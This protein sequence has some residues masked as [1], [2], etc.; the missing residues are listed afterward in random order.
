MLRELKIAINQSKRRILSKNKAA[1]LI[2]LG[3][4]ELKYP[5]LLQTVSR[6]RKS[7]VLEIFGSGWSLSSTAEMVEPD[8]YKV[9]FNFSGYSQFDFDLYFF[10]M[11]ADNYIGETQRELLNALKI[12]HLVLKNLWSPNIDVRQIELKKYPDF[13]FI[14]DVWIPQ[15]KNRSFSQVKLIIEDRQN[16]SQI[17]ATFTSMIAMGIQSEFKTIILHGIDFMGEHFFHS[18]NTKYNASF[19]YGRLNCPDGKSYTSSGDV[20]EYAFNNT[21]LDDKDL[22]CA[23]YININAI[24]ECILLRALFVLA[25][26]RGISIRSHLPSVSTGILR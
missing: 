20:A 10:E 21:I 4:S 19:N 22:E 1:A 11:T 18:P 24:H 12:K 26:N 6:E 5:N 17:G 15:D 16:F 2:R 13:K 8:S 3:Y 7:N 25:A 9:G 23:N 14:H